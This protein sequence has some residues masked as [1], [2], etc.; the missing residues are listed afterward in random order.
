MRLTRVVDYII[1]HLILVLLFFEVL[2]HDFYSLLVFLLDE[3]VLAVDHRS[4]GL[5]D[6]NSVAREKLC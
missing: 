6:D 5:V 4:G 3:G 1:D 2:G